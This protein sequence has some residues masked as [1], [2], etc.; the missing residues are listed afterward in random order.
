[1]KLVVTGALG[2][3]G[4]AFIRSLRPGEFDEVVLLDNLRTQRYASLFHL[5][6]GVPFRFFEE[7]ILTADLA[8][9]FEDA[10]AVVHLAAFTDAG[11]SFESPAEMESVNGEGAEK[12]ARACV[13]TGARLIF[14]SSTS[15][16]GTP[17]TT[18]DES[19]GD[20]GLAPQTPYAASKLRTEAFLAALAAEAG[21][22]HV[23]LRLGTIFGPSPG[24]RFH[25]AVNKFA[26]QACRGE[27]LTVWRTAL[28]QVRPYLDLDDACAALRFVLRRDLFAGGT[29]NVL[30]CNATVAQVLEALRR[31][32]PDCAPRL[33]DARAMNALSFLVSPE[34]FKALGFE[35]G[36]S[37]D[38]GLRRTV[39]WL[40]NLRP[41][42]P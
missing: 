34:K 23:I 37:L 20:A 36:G 5:P 42:N 8:R 9:R 3:I 26:W 27:P 39:E 1:M 4:S 35:Y 11:A 32:V 30:T 33:V 40:R 16:Y 21:L 31:H 24:M 19:C 7:D 2:H 13:E 15:V 18:V 17:E 41:E 14:P 29:Y 6:E 25:T 10:H 28:D 22:R 12:V 38:E